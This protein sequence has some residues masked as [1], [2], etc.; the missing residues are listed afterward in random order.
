[1]KG[2]LV[3]DLE[4]EIPYTKNNNKALEEFALKLKKYED[5]NEIKK[6]NKII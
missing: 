2:I 6:L 3:L 4:S 5:D 1:V